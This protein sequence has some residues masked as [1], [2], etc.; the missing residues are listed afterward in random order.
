MK[1][2]FPF[3]GFDV[4]FGIMW[5]LSAVIGISASVLIVYIP[6]LVAIWLSQNVS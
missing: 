3:K 4:A 2:D 1:N 6:Y 5:V